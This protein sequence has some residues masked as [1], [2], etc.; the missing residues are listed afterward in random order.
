MLASVPD[1]V[2]TL[3]RTGTK[4]VYPKLD[5]PVEDSEELLLAESKYPNA[6]KF[7]GAMQDV[8]FRQLIK[9][10]RGHLT[11]TMPG[12]MPGDVLIVLNRAPILH[13][14]RKTNAA[15]DGEPE[16]WEFV[17]DGYVYPLECENDEKRT[18]MESK[19]GESYTGQ[20]SRAKINAD[21]ADDEEREFVFI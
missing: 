3:R 10:K 8:S 6:F 21:E 18:M 2:F 16:C 13:V 12:V 14:I 7:M 19:V 20:H 17:G 11:S 9:T 1:D 5:I 4:P 15:V